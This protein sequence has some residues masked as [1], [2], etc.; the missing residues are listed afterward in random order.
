MASIQ[1]AQ[2]SDFFLLLDSDLFFSILSQASEGEDCTWSHRHI[3]IKAGTVLYSLLMQAFL[4]N[5]TYS[6]THMVMCSAG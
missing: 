3:H 4:G 6:R 1:H 5:L 2:D